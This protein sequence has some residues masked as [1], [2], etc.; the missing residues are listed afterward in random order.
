MIGYHRRGR[1]PAETLAIVAGDAAVGG[2]VGIGGQVW[3][4]RSDNM[5]CFIFL[6][7][8]FSSSH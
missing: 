8:F 4:A 1:C 3:V 2:W 6:F 5:N 7:L